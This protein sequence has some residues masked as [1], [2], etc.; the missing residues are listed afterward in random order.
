MSEN[1]QIIGK[2]LMINSA[3][4]YCQF[5]VPVPRGMGGHVG[6]NSDFYIRFNLFFLFDLSNVLTG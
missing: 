5:E 6:W 4:F 1:N 3:T 2:K